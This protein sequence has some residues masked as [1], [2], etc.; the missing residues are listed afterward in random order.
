MSAPFQFKV[1]GHTTA[2]S[3]RPHILYKFDFEHNGTR[4]TFAAFHNAIGAGPG[5]PE[6]P[7]KRLLTTLFIPSA[8]V[9]DALIAERKEGLERY[10]N[11]LSKTSE[12]IP[13]ILEFLNADTTALHLQAFQLEDALPSTLS[14][15]TFEALTAGAPVP[16]AKS[17]QAAAYYPSWSS[18]AYIPEKLDYSRFDI[19]FFGMVPGLAVFSTSRLKSPAAFAIPNTS[20]ALTWSPE[21][22][23]LL[24]RLVAAA[25]KSGKGTKIVLSV[26]KSAH[27]L[28]ASERS[29]HIARGTANRAK[30]VTNLSNVVKAFSLDGIDIDWEYPN[31]V[32][33]GNPYGAK[34]SA[35]FLSLLKSLRGSL[36]PSKI[37]SAAVI[38]LPWLGPD[39]NPL[40][41]LSEYAA[42]LTYVN[43][44]P[45]PNAPLGDLCN[46]SSQPEFTAQAAFKQWTTAKFPA[47]KLMLGVPLYGYVYNSSRTMLEGFVDPAEEG[48]AP[49]SNATPGANKKI[50]RIEQ[51]TSNPVE[52]KA[53][54]NLKPWWGQAIPFN[55]LLASGALVKKGDGTLGQV[56]LDPAALQCFAEIRGGTRRLF[57]KKP[58][59]DDG[60]TLHNAIRAGLGK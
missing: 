23:S 9:D 51:T 34:D 56:Q 53:T 11:Q 25:K 17:F 36:G 38:D 22:Q 44:Q 54:A 52:I 31:S 4:H 46:G 40:T 19:L 32:G 48:D 18:D 43:L 14:R 16:D 24:K 45:G 35:N 33:A 30:F 1:S 3:P 57:S 42:E 12:H 6:L 41:D 13:A 28:I 21:D 15:T 58:D 27:S 29:T 59:Q 50:E 5:A 2:S 49:V 55:S 26:G 10:L 60:V 37:I 20:S 7:P 8:W 39:G 47:S